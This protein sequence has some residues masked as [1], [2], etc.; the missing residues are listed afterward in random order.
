[1]QQTT[2]SWVCKIP[3]VM[4]CSP[5]WCTCLIRDI[6]ILNGIQ[7]R[8]KRFTPRKLLTTQLR[9]SGGSQTI[10]NY[11]LPLHW[12]L[13]FLN[14][15]PQ[16]GNAIVFPQ[17]LYVLFS[18]GSIQSTTCNKLRLIFF[19]LATGTSVIYSSIPCNSLPYSSFNDCFCL[20]FALY[21]DQNFTLRIQK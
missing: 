18:Y 3:L 14:F 21:F 13:S 16:K 12:S 10:S 2:L 11:L 6:I 15:Q 1:M 5:I 4:I 19:I 9:H 20:E 8:D 7:R 17:S